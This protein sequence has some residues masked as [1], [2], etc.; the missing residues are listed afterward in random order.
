MKISTLVRHSGQDSYGQLNVDF[1][2]AIAAAYPEICLRYSTPG[3]F[4][5][6][7]NL[8]LWQE[9]HQW[10]LDLPNGKYQSGKHFHTAGHGIVAIESSRKKHNLAGCP[11]YLLSGYAYN[12]DYR[13]L[14]QTYWLLAKNEDT[15][16]FL[17]KIR[18]QIAKTKDFDTIRAWMWSLKKDEILKARQGDL[19][20]IPK[21]KMCGQLKIANADRVDIGNHRIYADVVT[22][23]Q[24]RVYVLNPRAQHGEHNTVALQGIYELRLAR[25]WEMGLGD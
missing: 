2:E 12:G 9:G 3:S 6:S 8:R 5:H 21:A 15:S 24:H 25:Q 23:T 19:G 11:L 18:P 7:G 16:F 22:Q 13:S 20:F 4:G 17:H 10:M 1:K 14:K